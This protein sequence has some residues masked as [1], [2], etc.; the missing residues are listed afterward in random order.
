MHWVDW[1][2]MLLPLAICAAIALHARRYVRGVADF[3]AGGRNAG[4]FLIC[5]AKSEQGAGAAMYVSSFQAFLAAGFTLSWWGQLSVPAALLVAITGYVIY[6]YRQT[7]A[8]TLGQF[9]EMRYSRNFRLFA[10]VLGL[11]AGL[12]NFGIIPAIGARF[13]V[14]FLGLPQA[15]SLLPG[16]QIPTFVLLMFLFLSVCVFMTTT[17]GQVSVLLTDC[18]EGMF[19]QV[20]YTLIAVVLLVTVFNWAETKTVLLS[21]PPGK[22]LVNPFDSA[23]HQNFNIWYVL[24]G[25]F[26]IF[27]RTMAWQN[28]HAFNSSAATPHEARMGAILGRWRMFAS[29]VMVTLLSVCA[30]TYFHTHG[31]QIDANLTSITDPATRDQM[32]APVALTMMLPTGIKGALLSICI[33]GIIAGDGIH[34]HSWGSILIQDVILPL[35]KKPLSPKQHIQLLRFSIVGVAVWA[36]FFGWFFP[37]TTYVSFWW[38]ITEAVFISG[39]GVALIGGLYWSRGTAAGAWTA[40]IVGA[41]LALTGIGVEGYSTRVLKKPFFLTLPEISFFVSVIAI[42]L[43]ITVSKLTCRKPHDMDKLLNRGVFAVTSDSDVAASPATKQPWFKKIVLL[44]IDHQFTLSDKIITIGITVWSLLWFAVFGIGTL[45]YFFH[46]WSNETWATYWLWSAIYLPVAIGAITT[47][48]FTWGCTTDMIDFFRRLRE[49]PADAS[50]DGT[51]SEKESG[52]IVAGAFD[53]RGTET[54]MP[55]RS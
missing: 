48:W 54:G 22:S 53:G 17:A 20:F 6:R 1:L 4:R 55:I 2:I 26:A 11:F 37:Q 8:M 31:P 42:T 7:R 10:G 15:I 14:A 33:M 30:M 41:V 45:V 21:A 35:R 5:T 36:F 44:G 16:V 9:F 23:G 46:P 27:Y 32:R 12:L 18:A 38:A 43:Y 47:I 49:R 28:S 52:P 25:I 19:S 50:D 13:M 29:A 24:I 34:L 39:A 40:I 3:M 51:V